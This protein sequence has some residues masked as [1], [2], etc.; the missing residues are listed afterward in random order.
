MVLVVCISRLLILVLLMSL[1]TYLVG[2]AGPNNYQTN[3]PEVLAQA[4][5]I[6]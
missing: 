4:N 3:C 1:S 6:L 5:G 2:M